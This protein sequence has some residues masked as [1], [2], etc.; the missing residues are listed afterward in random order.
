MQV[1][2]GLVGMLPKQVILICVRD[3]SIDIFQTKNL[4]WFF[5]VTPQY[6]LS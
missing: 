6:Q 2:G 5:V 4:M 3:N 1:L